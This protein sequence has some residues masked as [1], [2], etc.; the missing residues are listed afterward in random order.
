[1][2]ATLVVI[3]LLVRSARIADQ[4]RRFHDSFLYCSA[5][6]ITHALL[7]LFTADHGTHSHPSV[8][9]TAPQ[10]DSATAAL[11]THH[12][13]SNVREKNFNATCVVHAI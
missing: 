9:C 11:T 8:V 4:C 13:E 7:G 3:K 6:T 5:S 10:H 2:L 12:A 1:M